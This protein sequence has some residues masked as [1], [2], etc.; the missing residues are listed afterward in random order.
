[1]N[2][3]DLY[4]WAIVG[5]RAEIDKLEKDINRGK[6]LLSEYERGQQPK[7]TKSAQEIKE[8]IAEK[9]A[10]IERLDKERFNLSWKLEVELK[11]K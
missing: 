6:R 1:M 8:V 5:L 7:T 11:D 4:K 2:E 10:E 3:K 9:R